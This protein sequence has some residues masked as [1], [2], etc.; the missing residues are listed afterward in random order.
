[1]SS[2]RKRAA[3]Q[4]ANTEA[5]RLRQKLAFAETM[6]GVL[7]SAAEYAAT[8]HDRLM[9]LCRKLHRAEEAKNQQDWTAVIRALEKVGADSTAAMGSNAEVM[10]DGPASPAR[11]PAP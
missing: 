7:K 2:A 9:D 11:R 8:H 4:K 5:E 3:I 1:M 6:L 10:G